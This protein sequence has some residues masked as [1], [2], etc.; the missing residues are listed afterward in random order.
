MRS[1]QGFWYKAEHA[2]RRGPHG[3]E[4]CVRS[5]RED[6]TEGAGPGRRLLVRASA[7]SLKETGRTAGALLLPT[8]AFVW[9]AGD[10]SAWK[11]YKEQ[12]SAGTYEK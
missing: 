11:N 8:R 6:A 2:W 10:E 9:M 5:E 12:A 3:W 7:E 1:R 4:L